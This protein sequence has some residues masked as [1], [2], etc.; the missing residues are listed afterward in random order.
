MRDDNPSPENAPPGRGSQGVPP[1]QEMSE[2]WASIMTAWADLTTGWT[3]LVTAWMRAGG[4][5]MGMNPM[6]GMNPF[7]GGPQAATEWARQVMEC[8]G[9]VSRNVQPPTG[10]TASA[11]PVHPPVVTP[12]P[13]APIRARE[14][15]SAALARTR[16]HAPPARRASED[17][18]RGIIAHR[19][20][21]S[22]DLPPLAD[23]T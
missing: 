6:M 2:S 5:W 4:P 10:T 13:S 7:M 17:H 3:S 9:R 8:M 20:D 12:E 14:E 19:G 18:V 11:P 21:P 22:D 15:P 23:G 16:P 1:W